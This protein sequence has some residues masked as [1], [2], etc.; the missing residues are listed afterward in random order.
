MAVSRFRCWTQF[1][2][3]YGFTVKEYSVASKE[4]QN[5]SAQWL[6]RAA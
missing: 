2:K 5:Q 1:A 6:G 4:M 3:D